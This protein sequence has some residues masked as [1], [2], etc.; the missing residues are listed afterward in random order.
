MCEP[1]FEEWFQ[2]FAGELARLDGLTLDFDQAYDRY[3]PT[4]ESG[5]CG[6]TCAR[7]VVG[8]DACSGE[9]EEAE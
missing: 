1:T 8:A 5:I 9:W 3:L 2:S 4:F 6:G 7:H